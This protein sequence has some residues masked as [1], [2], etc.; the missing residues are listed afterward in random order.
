V[1]GHVHAT[2]SPAIVL[3]R[4]V[5]RVAACCDIASSSLLLRCNAHAS[6]SAGAIDTPSHLRPVLIISHPHS[7]PPVT[8]GTSVGCPRFTMSQRTCARCTTTTPR[9]MGRT[10]TAMRRQNCWT[11]TTRTQ[12][13]ISMQ[14]RAGSSI[15]DVTIGLHPGCLPWWW[16][17]TTPRMPCAHTRACLS[18]REHTPLPRACTHPPTRTH[19]LPRRRRYRRHWHGTLTMTNSVQHADNA[20]F[21]PPNCTNTHT[22]TH[23]HTHATAHAHAHAHPPTRTHMPNRRRVWR[24]RRC[25]ATTC[26]SRHPPETLQRV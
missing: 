19:A 3:R 13:Q 26:G 14:V 11:L 12:W 18:A 9:T 21:F 10:T 16:A 6:V 8:Q 23:A 15:S 20:D 25:I 2:T 5:G 1:R 17:L 22:H 24:Y 7:V 4:D